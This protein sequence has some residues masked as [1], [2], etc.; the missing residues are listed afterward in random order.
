MQDTTGGT[1]NT[2][3][4]MP[5]PAG[6]EVTGGA[7]TPPQNAGARLD[8]LNDQR[9]GERR[10]EGRQMAG[11]VESQTQHHRPS[12]ANPEQGATAPVSGD[13]AEPVEDEI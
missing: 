1:K 13:D 10:M 4:E 6:A 7:R 5:A 9:H 2:A 11:G 8:D 12:A 3:Q